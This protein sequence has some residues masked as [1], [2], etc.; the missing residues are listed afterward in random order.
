MTSR[1]TERMLLLSDP[2]LAE[3]VDRQKQMRRFEHYVSQYLPEL[4]AGGMRILD[5]GTGAGEMLEVA[6]RMR[7]DAVG[8]ERPRS[9]RAEHYRL[10]WQTYLRLVELIHEQR[11][12]A[13][14]YV[15]L[16]AIIAGMC[17]GLRGPFHAINCRN[18]LQH[19]F[20]EHFDKTGAGLGAFGRWI[21]TDAFARDWRI[22]IDWCSE[23]LV[24]GGT[25]LLASRGARNLDEY[26]EWTRMQA[27]AAG[28]RVAMEERGGLV[29]KLVRERG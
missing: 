9:Q 13:V 11:R 26:A 27:A 24:S 8:I 4:H 7:N 2:T 18:G 15:D 28:W 16:W 6:Q 22:V 10:W 14:W 3:K 17:P 12:L 21:F 19:I 23:M 5:I 29:I 1:D 25:I 20:K